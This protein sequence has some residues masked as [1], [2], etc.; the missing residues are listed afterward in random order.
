MKSVDVRDLP[1]CAFGPQC[2]RLLDDL[3]LPAVPT[4]GRLTSLED[5]QEKRRLRQLRS[6]LATCPTCAAL[7]A[8]A[9]RARAQQRL[10]LYHMLKANEQ[11]VPPTVHTIIEAV[12][13]TQEDAPL[14]RRESAGHLAPFARPVA[15]QDVHPLRERALPRRGLF[16]SVLA[17]ATVAV[18]ILAAGLLNHF[19]DQA[20][21][22]STDGGSSPFEHRQPTQTLS[23][24]SYGWDT[25]LVGLT[26]LSASGMVK[27]FT[28][29]S[30]DAPADRLE[31]IVSS[32]RTFVHVTMEGI[33]GDGQSLLY[34]LTSLDRRTYTVYSPAG[35]LHTIYQLP[36]SA[37]GNAIWVDDSRILVQEGAGH[38]IELDTRRGVVQQRWPIKASRLL[39]YRQPFLYFIG[40]TTPAALYRV[41][42]SAP[43]ASAQHIADAPAGTRF[44]LSADSTTVLYTGRGPAGERGIYAVRADGTDTHLLHT[45]PGMPIGYT[46]DNALLLLQQVESRLE[47]IRLGT[48]PAQAEHVLLAN[49]APG[50]IS[51]CG[52]AGVVAIIQ[53]CAGSI[54]LEPS[55]RGLLLHAY[56]AN[57]SH[58]LVYDNLET[59]ASR[60]VLTLPTDATVQLPGWSKMAATP[61][62]ACLCA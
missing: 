16:Q 20:A 8:E 42:L 24:E 37:G 6:H 17:L 31:R 3:D 12:R 46:E 40:A 33:S 7:L 45:G 44:W 48:T 9:R 23:A 21:P 13:R 61:A 26:M 28:F 41:D 55:G 57:G 4:S 11:C 19:A 62:V 43:N 51:L 27:G 38:V 32:N 10:M 49:A 35:G 34:D 5:L 14:S 1:P 30:Y 2:L 50:A 59:G 54:A 60:T 29:Y 47:V 15:Q 25:V 58:G 39:C 36:A 22:T 56:Y 53:L 18:V 52:A